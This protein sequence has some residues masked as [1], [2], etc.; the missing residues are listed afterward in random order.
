MG[1]LFVVFSEYLTLAVPQN[2]F[3]NNMWIFSPSWMSNAVAYLARVPRVLWHTMGQDC[4][5][6]K[7]KPSHSESY[8]F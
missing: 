7:K 3:W 2:K 8:R 5:K 6:C 1:Q 4:P